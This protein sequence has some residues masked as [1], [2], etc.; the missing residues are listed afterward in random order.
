MK[1]DPDA[2]PSTSDSRHSSR[3]CGCGT[4]ASPRRTPPLRPGRAR[5]HRQPRYPGSSDLLRFAENLFTALDP[6][7]L[8][9]NCHGEMRPLGAAK[10]AIRRAP[11]FAG[12]D[13]AAP[14]QAAG[15]LAGNVPEGA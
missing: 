6:A 11:G 13:T 5:T 8:L 4:R 1:A 7:A 12:R 15:V 3:R 14:A 9:R 10:D 2:A